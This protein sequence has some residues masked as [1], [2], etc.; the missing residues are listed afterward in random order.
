MGFVIT[1]NVR[2]ASPLKAFRRSRTGVN[3][4][5]DKVTDEELFVR[6]NQWINEGAGVSIVVLQNEKSE[7]TQGEATSGSAPNAESEASDA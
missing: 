6:C 3:L 1:F 2:M 5:V 4:E 7:Q